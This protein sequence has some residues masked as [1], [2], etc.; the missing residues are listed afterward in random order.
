MASKS[1]ERESWRKIVPD[2]SGNCGGGGSAIPPVT[3][4]Q[5]QI[6]QLGLSKKGIA[7][8][9]HGDLPAGQSRQAVIMDTAVGCCISGRQQS[10][11]EPQGDNAVLAEITGCGKQN[12]RREPGLPEK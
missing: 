4:A 9:A 5:L 3:P 12:V 6:I 10:T 1:Y 7:T 11:T 8:V 2:D